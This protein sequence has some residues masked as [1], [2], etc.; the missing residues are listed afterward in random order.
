MSE[1][2]IEEESLKKST[3]WLE[4][5]SGH[6]GLV[7]VEVIGCTGLPN[8]DALVGGVS[9]GNKTDAFACLV[10]EGKFKSRIR[11][12]QL[13]RQVN[14]LCLIYLLRTDCIVQTDVI[15]D[16]LSPRW[17]PWSNRAFIFHMMHPSS[18]LFI[19]VFDFD[20]ADINNHDG[21][22]RITVDISKFKPKLE[23]TVHYN[24]YTSSSNRDRKSNGTITIR[25]RVECDERQLLLSSIEAVPPNVYINCRRKKDFELARYTVEGE[26]IRNKYSLGRLGEYA[27][28]LQSYQ[29]ALFYIKEGLFNVLLW[30]GHVD[31]ELPYD[32]SQYL[33]RAYNCIKSLE[34]RVGIKPNA[35]DQPPVFRKGDKGTILTL[36]LHSFLAFMIGTTLIER[37]QFIPSFSMACLGW[38]MVAIMELRLGN[39]SPWSRFRP[40]QD[41]VWILVY[42]HPLKG[43]EAIKPGQNSEKAKQWSEYWNAKISKAEAEARKRQ[44]EMLKLQNELAQQMEDVGDGTNISSQDKG[45]SFDPLKAY[46]F[47]I[48][49]Q[50]Q[51]I[52]D[53]MR[54]VR[55]VLIWEEYYFSFWLTA[56]SFALSV[57]FLF[58]PWRFCLTWTIRILSWALLG[59]WMKLVDIYHF[60]VIENL[61]EQGKAQREKQ[62]IATQKTTYDDIVRQ[63][64]IAKEDAMKIKD[65]KVFKFGKYIA[66]V[67]I[68]KVDRIKDIPLPNS[69]AE[70]Y[71]ETVTLVEQAMQ[72][73]G[74]NRIRVPG[75]H[76]VGSMIP[77][78]VT[79]SVLAAHGQPTLKPVAEVSTS[80]STPKAIVKVGSVVVGAAV[81]TWFAVPLIASFTKSCLS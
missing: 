47:P 72:E 12:D 70:I 52:V 19:G 36:P 64:R 31:V 71:E 43:V 34:N 51:W 55:N 6:L 9:L 53:I 30:R 15:N 54:I 27:Q 3:Q 59:P 45:I 13:F 35:K 76:L 50:L 46:L 68:L 77:K 79:A 74:K 80:D 22:G 2:Q 75:Q 65:M 5:G 17:M 16:C 67:P 48:Q 62:I 42:G 7:Y 69:K 21:I 49:L 28:E 24:L 78:P 81:L 1:T 56:G 32:I 44:E 37:P 10:F 57:V 38:M 33:K 8:L 41:L 20:M 23:Y 29:I 63:A 58:I 60:Q 73:A 39:P 18:Q 4:A 25:V 40:F 14:L 26:D 61:D 11:A 66:W